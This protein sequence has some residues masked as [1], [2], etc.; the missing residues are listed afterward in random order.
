[1]PFVEHDPWRQQFFDGIPCPRDVVIPTDDGDCWLL[2]PHLRHL[3]NKLHIAASQGLAAAPHGVPPAR[4]PVFSKPIYNLK[5]MG[6]GSRLIR[7]AAA[8]RRHQAP[9]HMWMRYLTGAHISTDVALARGRPVWWR[10]TEGKSGRGG[11]F[12]YWMVEAAHRPRLEAYCGAWLR[13]ELAGF[14]GV[15]NLE[16]IGG[17]IIEIHLRMSDQWPDLYGAG[18]AESLVPLYRDGR[19]RF[20]DRD[21]HTGY[22][23]V[24]FGPHGRR[25]RPI[26]RALVAALAAR[27]GISSIQISFH[28]DR[29]PEA[30]SMPPG[31]FRLAIVNC[32]SLDAGRAVRARLARE[33]RSLAKVSRAPAR[34]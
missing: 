33:F 17:R 18:W 20:A 5:G 2:Y 30:H 4:Y 31:G 29:P 19:W 21:R 26:D 28:G 32:V 27:P 10:H 6:K 16:T 9:G 34:R 8:L 25:Y 11:T 14:S 7:N 24:L 1:M 12:D 22:S 23:V 3:H 15:V 13:R